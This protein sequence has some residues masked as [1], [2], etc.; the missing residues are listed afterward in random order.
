MPTNNQ[1][2]NG[3]VEKIQATQKAIQSTQ[4][5]LKEAEKVFAHA[6]STYSKKWLLFFSF[7]TIGTTKKPCPKCFS[8]A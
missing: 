7:G 8:R 6:I 2:T 3:L 1:H 5:R 4:D